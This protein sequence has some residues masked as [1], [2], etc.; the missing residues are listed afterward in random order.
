MIWKS[1]VLSSIRGNG[2][3]QFFDEEEQDYVISEI[4]D[5]IDSFTDAV[6]DEEEIDFL[7]DELYDFCDGYNILIDDNEEDK[8]ETEPAAVEPEELPAVEVDVEPETVEEK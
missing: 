7:L 3:E 5:L 2:L 4:E 8:T 1:Q 6:E